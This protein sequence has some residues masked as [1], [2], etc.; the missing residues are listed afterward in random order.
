M[1]DGPNADRPRKTRRPRKTAA[2]R[3][4]DAASSTFGVL[5]QPT[6]AQRAAMDP[7]NDPSVRAILAE[8]YAKMAASGAASGAAT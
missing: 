4:A 7:R 2:Q 3:R 1:E 8:L 5:P 6:E